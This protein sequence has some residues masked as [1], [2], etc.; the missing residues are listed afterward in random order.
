MSTREILRL[1]KETKAAYP[2]NNTENYYFPKLVSN[3]YRHNDGEFG[4]RD[5]INPKPST[6]TE[7]YV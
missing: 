5:I 1:K 6:N 3:N 7:F 2:L 4:N